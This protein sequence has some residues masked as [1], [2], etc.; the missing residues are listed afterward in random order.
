MSRNLNYKLSAGTTPGFIGAKLQPAAGPLVGSVA[1]RA[2]V[3]CSMITGSGGSVNYNA[4]RTYKWTGINGGYQ[5]NKTPKSHISA[6]LTRNIPEGANIGML[7]SHVEWK[8][9]R[10]FLPRALGLNG[11]P[12]FYY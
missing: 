6:H 4:F 9:F 3:A 12:Y 2:L 5:Y 11:G 8:P 7:D 1:K 10:Q